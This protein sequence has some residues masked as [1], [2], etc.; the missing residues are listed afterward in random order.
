MTKTNEREFS[1]PAYWQQLLATLLLSLAA[2]G[3][4]FSAWQSSRWGG[5]QA[6]HFA[7]ASASRVEAVRA[8]GNANVQMSYDA[9]TFVQLVLSSQMGEQRVARLVGERF[10][11]K[12][13]RPFAEEWLAMKPLENPDA[14]PTPFEL[15]S[16]TNAQHQEGLELERT[17]MRYTEEAKR[18]NQHSDD[19][20]LATVFFALGL[21]FGGL[22]TKLRNQRLV[23]VLLVFGVLGSLL[24]L[25]QLLVLPFH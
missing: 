12:E 16:Y 4:A 15:K 2:V 10:L 19:Y 6:V 5:V 9:N 17:A 3:S 22:S 20:I 18:A 14:P 23:T 1:E 25:R 7:S 11:R 24:G 21:F 8:F 13:F